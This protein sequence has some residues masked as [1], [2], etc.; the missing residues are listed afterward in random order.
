MPNI[1]GWWL[2][3]QKCE[4]RPLTPREQ[5]IIERITDGCTQKE[6]A[7]ALGLSDAPVRVL[8]AR[9]MQKLGRCKRK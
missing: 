7:F 1:L 6:V 8:Y 4:R 9:A 3:A 2:A 5:Q